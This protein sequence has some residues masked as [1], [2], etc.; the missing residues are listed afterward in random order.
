M[1]TLFSNTSSKE[2][3]YDLSITA[4]FVPAGFPMSPNFTGSIDDNVLTPFSNF[5]KA[6]EIRS[7]FIQKNT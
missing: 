3:E 1:C 7:S 4:L 2:Y 6:S 5:V